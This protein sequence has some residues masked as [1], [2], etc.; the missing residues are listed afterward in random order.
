MAMFL[1]KPGMR[2]YVPVV[3]VE[4]GGVSH[5]ELWEN[6]TLDFSLENVKFTWSSK[7]PAASGTLYITSKR[8]IWLG[9]DASYDFDVPYITLHAV[10]RDP[11]TYPAP[12]VYCQLDA[13]E[14]LGDINQGISENGEEDDQI[15]EEED[16]TEMF[17]VPDDEADV[18]RLFEALSQAALLNPDP[19]DDEE[20]DDDF[21]FNADEVNL[22][23]AQAAALNAWESKFVDPEDENCN[24][25][26]DEMD[27]GDDD[28]DVI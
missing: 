5:P 21:I 4:E 22:G 16:H 2:H 15:E 28:A 6:E 27:E 24:D 18:L 11:A 10:S 17:L 9:A 13:E 12:C 20:G 26:G 23:A 8:V 14:D 25:E 1:E 19:E 7:S 3:E